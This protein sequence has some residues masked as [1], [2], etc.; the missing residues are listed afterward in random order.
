MLYEMNDKSLS[1]IERTSFQE[2]GVMEA[3]LQEA[4]REHPEFIEDGLFVISDE[5]SDWEDSG[6][7][8]DLLCIDTNGS[9][10][11]VELKRS[12]GVHM[13]LQVIR[14]A[15]MM[16]NSSTQRIIEGHRRYPTN[17]NIEGS[18]EERIRE[19]LGL[20]ADKE[21]SIA[22][23]HPRIVLVSE[24][25]NKEITTSVLWLN[26]MGLDIRCVRVRAYTDHGRLLLDIDQVIPL[27]EA[28]DYLVKARNREQETQALQ[29]NT[30]AGRSAPNIDNFV[31]TINELTPMQQD[32]FK[33]VISLVRERLAKNA[34]IVWSHTTS[35][36]A[37]LSVRTQEDRYLFT[38]YCNA[39]D[40]NIQLE[41]TD[42]AQERAPLAWQV[43]SE[44]LGWG[45]PPYNHRPY[46][47]GPFDDTDIEL[48]RQVCVE[49]AE[50]VDQ[51]G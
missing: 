11:V 25:F 21:I 43:L 34:I 51:D 14:Y 35:R 18:V 40:G 17:R 44:K 30:G 16:A 32:D 45:W 5:F 10:V 23:E 7:S 38:L 2:Q 19:H 39:S 20:T 47:V 33:G 46:K 28:E 36:G 3:A 48:L 26:E 1:G 42:G 22:T 9:L 27:P 4:L 31:D 15:A 13:E 50:T 49:A 6:R 41:T 29:R 24:D 8:I 12:D 37:T